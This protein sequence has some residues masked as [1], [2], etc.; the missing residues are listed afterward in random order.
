MKQKWEIKEEQGHWQLCFNYKVIST[1]QEIND[2]IYYSYTTQFPKELVPFIKNDLLYIYKDPTDY[3]IY[4]TTVEPKGLL[5]SKTKARIK[6]GED[7]IRVISLNRKLFNFDGKEIDRYIQLIVH[8]GVP[9][10]FTNV[11]A[12]IE[13][14]V[15]S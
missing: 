10:P 1:V 7:N 6:Y 13:I 2:T 4:I 3:H 12:K 15:K 14:A 8:L 5:Y 11:N 9:D